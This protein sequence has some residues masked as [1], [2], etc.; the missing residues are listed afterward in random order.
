MDRP[1]PGRRF[2]SEP[3]QPLVEHDQR[4]VGTAGA[5]TTKV[6]SDLDLLWNTE[7]APVD[8]EA[9]DPPGRFDSEE[10]ARE[11]EDRLSAL[12]TSGG[13]ADVRAQAGVAEA[14]MTAYDAAVLAVSHV[15]TPDETITSQPPA[16]WNEPEP[17]RRF[18]S[19]E[20]QRGPTPEDRALGTPTQRGIG[21][22]RVGIDAVG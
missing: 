20:S 22:W 12:G 17:A 1:E 16:G 3:G 19:E 4:D 10:R 18:D 15:G 7:G 6:S 5:S 11:V 21:Q 8:A 14:S 13:G 2:D 9:P